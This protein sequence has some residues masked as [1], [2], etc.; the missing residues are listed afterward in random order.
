MKNP[1][2]IINRLSPNDALAVLKTLAHGDE[3]LAA[4]IAKIATAHLSEVNPEHVALELYDE[5]DSLEV[6]EIWDRAGPSRHGYVDPG[7]AADEM[8]DEIIAPYL[9]ELA[10]YQALGMNAEANRMCMGLL[11][12][13]YRFEDQSSSTFKEWAPDAAGIFADAVVDA[14]KAGSSRRADV[15]ALRTFI[16]EELYGWGPR[17][18]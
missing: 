2:E 17:L 4:R 13:L 15:K 10:K 11:L 7:E 16:E 18:V 12:W 3:T 1:H 14:W 9:E 6:E 8:V 5:L